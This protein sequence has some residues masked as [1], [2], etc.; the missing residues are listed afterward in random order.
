MKQI[1]LIFPPLWSPFSVCAALPALKGILNKYDLKNNIYDFNIDFYREILTGEFL[2]GAYVTARNFINNKNNIN[3]KKKYNYIYNYLKR[4]QMYCKYLINNIDKK[5]LIFN[6]KKD[7]YNPD[8][9]IEAN[10]FLT[11]SMELAS[12]PYYPLIISN[13]YSF[14]E[15]LYSET[16]TFEKIKFFL[17]NDDDNIFYKFIKKYIININSHFTGISVSSFSQFLCALT[18]AKELKLKDK[19]K[20]ITIG[21]QYV[22]HMQHIITVNPFLFR[23]IDVFMYGDGENVLINT[24]KN[25]KYKDKLYKTDNLIYLNDKNKIVRNASKAV[26][27]KDVPQYCFDGLDFSKYLLPHIVLPLQTSRSCY[28]GKCIFCN[29]THGSIYSQKKPETVADE[30]EEICKKYA[31]YYFYFTDSCF[32]PAFFSKLA[33]EILK[34][35]LKIYY[36]VP[37]RI[38]AEFNKTLLKKLYKSGFRYTSTGFESASQRILDKYNKGTKVNNFKKYLSAIHSSNIYLAGTFMLGFP[39]ETEKEL[40]STI[41]FIKNNKKYFDIINAN[42][43][44]LPEWCILNKNQEKYEIKK[45]DIINIDDLHLSFFKSNINNEEI[46]KKI[47]DIDNLINPIKLAMSCSI[48][49]ELLYISKYGKHCLNFICQYLNIQRKFRKVIKCCRY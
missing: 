37:I 36:F 24:I 42:K 8:K 11:K 41:K 38:E 44:M 20:F 35:K 46:S 1:S 15:E 12:L 33:D 45:E 31:V 43:V 4:N 3:N 26:F 13:N 49:T 14:K 39:D 32:E 34:R 40:E 2:Y 7:F 28:W 18:I 16:S 5:I 29:Y 23:Y 10:I 30:L 9:I 6:N 21:G 17:E 48:E 27:M 25:Y 22:T 47:Q 19:R